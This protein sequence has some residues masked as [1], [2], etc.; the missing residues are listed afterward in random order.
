LLKLIN[1]YFF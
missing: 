1:T